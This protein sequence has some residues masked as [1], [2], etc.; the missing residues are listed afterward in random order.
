MNRMSVKINGKLDNFNIDFEHNFFSNGITVL[1][2]PNGSGKST[3]ISCIGGFIDGLDIKVKLN[4]IILDGVIKVPPHKRPLGIMFQNP[5]LFEHLTVNQNL[6]FAIKRSKKKL[7]HENKIETEYLINHLELHQL[8]DRY[9]KNLSGG[10]KLRV[11]L[12]RTLLTQ[13]SYLLLDE[14][15]SEI[16]I[17]YKA[18]LLFL[19][20]KINKEFN[21]PILY[22][23]H[24]IEEISQIADEIVLID[25]GKKIKSGVIAEIINDKK[26]QRLIGRF[27]TSSIIHGNVLKVDKSLNLTTLDVNGQDLLVPGRPGSKNKIVR[28]RIRSRDIIVSPLKINIPIT[29]NELRGIISKIET[30]KKTAFSE[31]LIVLNGKKNELPLQILRARI[32]TY[33]LKK[34]N[35]HENSKI[36]IY[37]SAVSIDRQ[38]YQY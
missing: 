23:S 38:A 13:P 10:E 28:V 32:T 27:E 4:N 30:E 33:N 16:D 25:K 8:L 24:S 22:V 19:L 20:K 18:K 26:F 29:E 37:I 6:I 15:M 9:P 1:Y 31:V 3:I 21:I 2:G 11:S 35:L 36:F 34:M 7:Y 17:K 5:I 14:P 12:A